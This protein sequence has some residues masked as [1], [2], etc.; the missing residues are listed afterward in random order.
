MN[1]R[2]FAPSVRDRIRNVAVRVLK[3]AGTELHVSV[4][5]AE[6]LSSLGLDASITS[7]TVNTC[8]HDDPQLRFTRVGRGTQTPRG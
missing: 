2:T 5:T 4:I 7:K 1:R 8:L 6:V 3:N